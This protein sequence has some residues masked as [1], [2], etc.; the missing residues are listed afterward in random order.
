MDDGEGTAPEAAEAPEAPE[1]SAGRF[2][3]LAAIANETRGRATDRANEL[4]VFQLVRT[5]V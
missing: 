5:L 4:L 1:T 3:R 2:A